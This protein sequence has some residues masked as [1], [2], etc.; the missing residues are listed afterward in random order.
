MSGYHEPPRSDVK[1]RSM[2]YDFGKSARHAE[3]AY[4][5]ILKEQQIRIVDTETLPVAKTL[6]S[7]R[8]AQRWHL[9]SDS[10]NLASIAW[11]I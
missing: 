8:C 7:T 9:Q 3:L 4:G 5:R 6:A 11:S 10:V 1:N 2:Y